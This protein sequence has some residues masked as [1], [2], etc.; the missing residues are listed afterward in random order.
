MSKTILITGTNGYLSQ[1]LFNYFKSNNYNVYSTSRKVID[2]STIYFNL[3][4]KSE[5]K[6]ENLKIDYLIHCSYERSTKYKNERNINLNGSLRLFKFAKKNNINLIYISS[7]SSSPFANSNYGKIKYEI[8]KIS[9]KYNYTVIKPGLLYSEKN[10]S[11]V[12]GNIEKFIKILPFIFL[13]KGNLKSQY[14]CKIIEINKVVQ[15]IIDNRLVKARVLSISEENPI[16]LENLC[17]NIA[18]QNNKKIKIIFINHKIIFYIIK[19]L[20]FFRINFG[21]R[22]DSLLSLTD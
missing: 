14:L 4:D 13:P 20:E 5:F 18:K 11:G 22:S 12:Y 16:T 15:S 1:N 19:L 17:R 9:L 21:I 8:E 7:L 2:S 10:S 3:R 6:L